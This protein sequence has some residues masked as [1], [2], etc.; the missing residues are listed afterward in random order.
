MSH[1]ESIFDAERNSNDSAI[2]FQGQLLDDLVLSLLDSAF[3]GV[4][5]PAKEEHHDR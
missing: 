1:R 3:A 5:S 4:F 2:N